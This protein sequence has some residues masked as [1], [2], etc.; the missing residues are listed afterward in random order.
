MQNFNYNQGCGGY[1]YG[2]T[3][4][5]S[6]TYYFV[7]GLE[8]AKAFQLRGG[9]SVLLMDNDN[10]ICYKKTVDIY[11]KTISLEVFDLVPHQEKPPVEYVTKEEFQAFIDNFNVKKE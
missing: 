11:G 5:Q 10:P 9:T 3:Q 6:N 1:G 4:P 8:G 7:S 2:Y